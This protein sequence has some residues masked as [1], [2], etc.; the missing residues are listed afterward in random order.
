LAA[1]FFVAFREGITGTFFVAISL[2]ARFLA[3]VGVSAFF[4]AWNAAQRFL[5]ASTIAFL[6]AALSFR[7]GFGASDSTGEKVFLD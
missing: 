4:A 2:A 7:F 3:S 1:T 6:P 5:V